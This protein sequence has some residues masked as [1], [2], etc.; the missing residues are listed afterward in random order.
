MNLEK[1][2][3]QL[4]KQV[5]PLGEP[6]SIEAISVILNTLKVQ[7]IESELRSQKNHNS[8]WMYLIL[9]AS[10]QNIILTT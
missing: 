5:S 2:I 1:A 6:A 7:Q 10:I 9:T 3:E 4:K 8:E